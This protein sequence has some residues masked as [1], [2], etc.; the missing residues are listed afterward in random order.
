MA[1][2]GQILQLLEE[3]SDE[4]QDVAVSASQGEVEN[5]TSVP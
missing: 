3:V 1:Y 2:V 5:E 4:E